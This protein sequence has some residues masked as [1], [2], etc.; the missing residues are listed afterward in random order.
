[1]IKR[2]LCKYLEKKKLDSI[3]HGSNVFIG[4][5]VKLMNPSRIYVGDN[6]Y[7]NGGY[8]CAGN[9]SKII[10]G[11]DCLISYD[12]H[13]RCT[14]HNYI[15]KNILIRNQGHSE[16]DIIIKDDCWIGFGAQIMSGITINTGCVIAAGAVVTHDTEP[17]CVYAGI[18]AKK[19]KERK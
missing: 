7:V 10:V 1:M 8:L 18:P 17:Y 15:D 11:N 4:K 5:D 3:N 14:G 12:V 2:V 6:S 19:I 16:A 13:I 9:N